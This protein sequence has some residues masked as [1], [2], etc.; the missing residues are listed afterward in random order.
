[1]AVNLTPLE[2]YNKAL[3][4]QK[5]ELEKQTQNLR[6]PFKQLVS[7]VAET[8]AEFAK[9]ASENLAGT[10][11]TWKGVITQG[12][13]ERLIREAHTKEY[14]AHNEIIK[15]SQKE[16]R[17]IR[18]K[19]AVEEAVL[20]QERID[21]KEKVA[22]KEA[23]LEETT[24]KQKERL[25]QIEIDRKTLQERITNETNSK[26]QD[27]FKRQLESLDAQEGQL[28]KISA[29][30][31]EEL[32][33]A[34][35]NQSEQNLLS[36]KSIKEGEQRLVDEQQGR[37]ESAKIVEETNEELEHQLEKASN[38]EGFDKFTGSIRTLTG[39][40]VDIEGILDPVA[41]YVGAF[42]DLGSLI[43]SPLAGVKNSFNE[44][45]GMLQAST[46]KGEESSEALK[47]SNESVAEMVAT[48]SKKTSGG[49]GKLIKNIGLTG[50]ALLALVAGVIALMNRFEGFDRFIKGLLG[51]EDTPDQT[52]SEF[53]ELSDAD[54]AGEK[55]QEL[56][57]QQEDRVESLE[58]KEDVLDKSAEAAGVAAGG[59]RAASSAISATPTASRTFATAIREG[60]DLA[61]DAT[62]LN[63]A[64]MRINDAGQFV[65]DASRGQKILSATSN[66]VQTGGARTLATGLKTVASKA[67]APVAILLTGA[68]VIRKLQESD[69]MAAT[70]EEMRAN[71]EITEED[72]QRGLE[73]IE[74][75][76]KEDV[77]RPVAATTAGVAASAAAATAAAPLLAAGPFGWVAYG[78][79]VIGAGV[80]A[81]LAADKIVD[82]SMTADDEINEILGDNSYDVNDAKED[83]KEMKTDVSDIQN[84][85]GEDIKEKTLSAE[86]EAALAL[87]PPSIQ[88]QINS[89][90][91][92]VL[93]VAD[94]GAQNPDQGALLLAQSS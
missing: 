65:K 79:I 86:E 87:M 17:E 76:K 5:R 42:R 64:G 36:E 12:K 54:K 39:G 24:L 73:L 27:H 67:A 22:E 47:E 53:D 28:L 29:K 80:T 81:S 40:L 15:E 35:D 31:E 85:Q 43:G 93:S 56:I 7:T 41:K 68:E 60:V 23:A 59:A 84:R 44:F 50:I 89:S 82:S 30:R 74:E 58:Y 19:H 38:T 51:Y 62:R 49:F 6:T 33:E 1:M 94:T 70:L 66:V 26:A 55:G 77:V 90:T 10:Q 45:K 16:E 92:E 3:V 14:K 32:K 25:D 83:L 69:D 48:S 11:D 34:K 57:D 46:E 52:K 63:S 18:R 61:G 21:H 78:A 9:I 8:N 20:D 75:K 88:T 37:R 71:E 72:Y 2:E 91:S 4:Q 13:K